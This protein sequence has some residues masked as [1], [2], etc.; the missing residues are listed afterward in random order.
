MEGEGLQDHLRSNRQ[1]SKIL[2]RVGERF[3]HLV[4]TVDT[5]TDFSGDFASGG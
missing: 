5:Y 3:P 2:R 4:Q 1:F